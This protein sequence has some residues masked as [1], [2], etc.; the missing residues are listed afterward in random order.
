[1]QRITDKTKDES[2]SDLAKAD[3]YKTLQ[4]KVKDMSKEEVAG[5]I[6]DLLSIK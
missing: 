2:E 4:W 5:T 3:L 1:M 6:Q